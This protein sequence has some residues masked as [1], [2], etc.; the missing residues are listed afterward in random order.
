M[1]EKKGPHDIEVMTFLVV[2]VFGG[3]AYIFWYFFHEQVTEVLRWIRLGEMWIGSLIFGDDFVVQTSAFGPQSLGVWK[4]WLPSAD[5]KAIGISEILVTTEVAIAPLKTIFCV[6]MFLMGLA[7]AFIEPGKKFQ[8]KMNLQALMEEQAKA[9]PPLHPFVEFNPLKANHRI[10]GK[11]VPEKL[12]LFA[13]ALAPEEWVAYN[14]IKYEGKRLDRKKAQSSFAKQLGKRWRG[15]E[16]LPIY[17]QGLYA[18]FALKSRR[19]RKEAEELLNELAMSWSAKD[20]FKPSSKLKKQIAM[21]LK[22]PAT[23]LDIKKFADKHAFETTALLRCLARARE[24]GGVMAPASFLWLRGV[25]RNLW[26]PLNNLGRKAFHP[27]AAGAMIHYI[28]ELVSGQKIPAPQVDDAVKGLEDMLKE[29]D[30]RPIPPLERAV[31]SKG[32]VII[33]GK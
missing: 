14:Q 31:D 1:A 13:E 16:Y 4:A 26:Y 15:P 23:G 10:L 28:Y 18:A 6:G 24:E 19:K 11:P 3:F 33:K 29:V 27:E 2:F 32:K 12:P 17:A 21:V 22:D 8:R 7:V 5:I 9:F 30:A 25:D 20:G